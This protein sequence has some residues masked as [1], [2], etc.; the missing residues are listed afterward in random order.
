M[1]DTLFSV[2]LLT[3]KACCIWLSGG[4]SED[5]LVEAAAVVYA[6]CNWLEN[7]PFDCPTPASLPFAHISA[8]WGCM[9]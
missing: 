5:G 2:P 3:E 9:P 4:L 1:T 8:T 7:M 6:S